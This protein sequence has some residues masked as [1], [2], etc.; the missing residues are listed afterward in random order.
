M[1]FWPSDHFQGLLP[2]RLGEWQPRALQ[3]GGHVATGRR[4]PSSKACQPQVKDDVGTHGTRASFLYWVTPRNI[5][6]PTFS[7]ATIPTPDLQ[8]KVIGTVAESVQQGLFICLHVLE[9]PR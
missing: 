2:V 9:L 3:L 5:R 7:H 8:R 4:K 1:H 6:L